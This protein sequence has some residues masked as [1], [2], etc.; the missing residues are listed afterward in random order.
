M[1]LIEHVGPSKSKGSQG[2]E[3]WWET[4]G[5]RKRSTKTH[6]CASKCYNEAK[7]GTLIKNIIKYIKSII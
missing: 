7:L 6:F 4:Q 3:G 1:G 5:R 2:K